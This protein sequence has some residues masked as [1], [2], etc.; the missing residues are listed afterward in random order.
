[1]RYPVLWLNPFYYPIV[2]NWQEWAEFV[3]IYQVGLGKYIL[4]PEKH[5]K[6]DAQENFK[7]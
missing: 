3:R 5:P 7:K 1:M 2:N 6:G 4:D